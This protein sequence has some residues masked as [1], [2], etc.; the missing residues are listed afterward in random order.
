MRNAMQLALVTPR[1]RILE[2]SVN[3][4]IATGTL[5]EFGVLPDHLPFL[6]TLKE[7]PFRFEKAGT[8]RTVQMGDGVCEV[9]PDRVVVLAETVHH[10]A[11]VTL[12]AIL[13]WEPADATPQRLKPAIARADNRIREIEQFHAPDE[14]AARADAEWQELDALTKRARGAVPGAVV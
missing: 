4:V 10:E 2:M 13:D 5:G 1:G 9:G 7:G 11:S 6:T 14:A 8:W 3:Q 12:Q